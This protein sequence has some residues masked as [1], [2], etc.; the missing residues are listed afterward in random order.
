M[1][2]VNDE[3]YCDMPDQNRTFHDLTAFKAF[4]DHKSL[5]EF[6]DKLEMMYYNYEPGDK[7][8]YCLDDLILC[9]TLYDDRVIASR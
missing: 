5:A 4:Q 9:N 1:S 3:R 7:V 6:S 2:Y 8:F